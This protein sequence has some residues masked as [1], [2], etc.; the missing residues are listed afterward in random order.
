MVRS[1]SVSP[2]ITYQLQKRVCSLQEAS[3]GWCYEH[4]LHQQTGGWK[5]SC[6]LFDSFLEKYS[7]C[8]SLASGCCCFMHSIIPAENGHYC[9]YLIFQFF[10]GT[11][12][13]PWV[14]Q[15]YLWIRIDFCWLSFWSPPKM[16]KIGKIQTVWWNFLDWNLAKKSHILEYAAVLTKLGD[17]KKSAKKLQNL[18]KN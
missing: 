2:L 1:N 5:L 6:M 15:Y 12:D 11:L 3:V 10:W 7:L 16:K 4:D 17:L 14:M 18:S 8:G 9:R 13:S